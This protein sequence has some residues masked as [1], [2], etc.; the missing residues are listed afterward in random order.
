MVPRRLDDERSPTM[1]TT[2]IAVPTSC[3][4][5][6][7]KLAE[8]TQRIDDEF[9]Q[10][11]NGAAI[12]YGALE[13]RVAD[14]LGDIERGLHAQVLARLDIDVPAIRVWGDEYRR[15]GRSESEYHTL[16]G[17]VRVM[18]TVYRK[19]VRNGD[20]LDPVSV[21]AGVVADGWLPHTARAMAHLIAQGTSR[22]AEAIARELARLPYSRSSFERVG[23]EVGTLFR[24]AQP[25]IEEVLIREYAVPA[26]A[27]SV[28]I[29]IDRVAL[30]MEEPI[31]APPVPIDPPWVAAALAAA[32]AH[33]PEVQAILDE[34][35]QGDEPKVARNF[36][37]AYVATVT[38]HD[39]EGE[40]L[41]TIRYGRMPKGDVRGLCRALVRDVTAM[42]AQRPELKVAYLTDG[43]SEFETLYAQ[44]LGMPL[45][46]DVVSLVDFWHAAEYLCTAAKVLEIKR[47]ARAG[48][49]RR[50]RHALKHEDDAA[51]RIVEQLEQ[52]GLDKVTLDGV[53]PV[54]AAIRYFRA[55]LPRMDYAAARR[56]GLPI[57]SGN[58]EATCKSLVT[59]RMKR[60][61]ARWKH[62]TGDE[63]MQLRALQL[64]DRWAPA[65]QRATR[66]LAKSVQIVGGL[67]VRPAANANHATAPIVS[68]RG[69]R[70]A[71]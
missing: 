70:T 46:P 58:V 47:K 11:G 45:G 8:L 7:T 59:V 25:R 22:E 12:D 33:A 27:R 36:R 71:A 19:T 52:S 38:L 66:P 60:P 26:E 24:R 3:A 67:G 68:G 31:E 69:A 17:T 9:A 42:R 30:P 1:T 54:E 62:T 63:V 10:A 15:I 39:G 14:V 50:W 65:V 55:R 32:P 28:S 23:H 13:Q 41:H 61:G 56:A 53:R 34:Q 16:A 2:T 6:C 4:A 49:F 29:S 21:R 51:A 44:H 40:S 5:L 37:M 18:R 57:G 43:A 20:T 48:Q 64:S 35:N